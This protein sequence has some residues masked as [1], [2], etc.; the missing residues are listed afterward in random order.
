MNDTLDRARQ[1]A[2][3]LNGAL[4]LLL[5]AYESAQEIREDPWQFAVQ[6]AEV[7]AAGTSDTALRVLAHDGYVLHRHET[8]RLS[9]PRRTF[10]RVSN[11]A[12]SEHTCLVLSPLGAAILRDV[13][14]EP[15]PPRPGQAGPPEEERPY[16]DR[17]RRLLFYRGRLV[18]GFSGKVGN[19]EVIV[20]S[21]Q[22]LHWVWRIDNPVPGKGT[23]L[24]AAARLE[25]AVKDFNR[26]QVHRLLRFRAIDE[27]RAVL[28]EPRR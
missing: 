26:S 14:A 7:K 20:A 22:E 4:N 21:F 19:Q 25:E 6:L 27:G 9:A 5:E 17:N 15:L 16:W 2:L 1:R 12:F 13:R 18:K 10:R 3:R 24:P 11:L 28:W 23:D 8:T